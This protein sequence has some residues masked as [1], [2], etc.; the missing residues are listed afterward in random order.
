LKELL[1]MSQCTPSM[2]IIYKWMNSQVQSIKITALLP[3]I[4]NTQCGT[5]PALCKCTS[6]LFANIWKPQVQG[7]RSMWVIV[8]CQT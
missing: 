8:S 4:N 1:E 3:G 2:T 5:N 7:H 6:M